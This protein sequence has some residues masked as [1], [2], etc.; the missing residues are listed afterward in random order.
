MCR[1]EE[2]EREQQTERL[3]AAVLL[4]SLLLGRRRLLQGCWD[5]KQRS[6]K[7][8]DKRERASAHTE[9]LFRTESLV[10]DHRGRLDQILQVR[11]GQS[12]GKS[13]KSQ[14]RRQ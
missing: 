14:S 4:M 1:D 11:T 5:D 10:V 13:A 3:C 6:A 9:Q 7:V 12:G 2:E 8:K